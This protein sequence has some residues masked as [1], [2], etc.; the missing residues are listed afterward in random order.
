MKK[1]I[2]AFICF[3]TT[4]LIAQIETPQLSPPSTLTQKVG[5][6]DITINYSRPSKRGRE[7]F[8]GLEPMDVVW[9]LGANANSTISF[10]DNVVFGKDT[11][12]AGKY[13]MYAKP[14][15]TVWTIYFYKTLDNWGTPE[16]WDEELVALAV[17][18][19]VIKLNAPVETFTISIDAISLKDAVLSFSWDQ[20]KAAIKFSAPT[21][22][23]VAKNIEKGL[24]GPTANDYYRAADYYYT[25][26]K[27]LKQALVWIDKAIELNGESRPFYIFRKKSLIQ[28]EMGDYK[29]AIASAKISLE[30]AEKSGRQNYVEM[31]QA[32]IEEWSKK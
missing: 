11:L 17:E 13:A 26:K 24:S 14:G 4:G 30:E 19:N 25:E 3:F 15:K 27:D 1:L 2:V 16:N 5:L 10:S 23:K 21:D 20:T 8:G 6:T 7:I 31:N 9:R 28:A 32:S 29:G 12:P 22:E 18:T